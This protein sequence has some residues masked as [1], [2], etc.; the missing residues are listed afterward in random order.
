M[1]AILKPYVVIASNHT[2]HSYART[3]EHLAICSTDLWDCLFQVP[4]SCPVTCFCHLGLCSVFSLYHYLACRAISPHPDASPTSGPPRNV[5]A[6]TLEL[7]ISGHWACIY[8]SEPPFPQCNYGTDCWSAPNIHYS[9]LP[10]PE[11]VTI[12]VDI[13]EPA[14][15]LGAI[16]PYSDQWN[17]SKRN[18]LVYLTAILFT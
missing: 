7:N 1:H 12:L 17:V 11:H 14:L 3:H 10:S 18:C 13:S 5:H 6:P 2:I 16:W 15:Q 4:D 9:L 8:S